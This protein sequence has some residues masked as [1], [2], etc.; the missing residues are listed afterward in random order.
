MKAIIH[1]HAFSEVDRNSLLGWIMGAQKQ[2]SKPLLD[3]HPAT[4]DALN[5]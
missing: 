4:A 2:Q 3:G 5:R 1:S